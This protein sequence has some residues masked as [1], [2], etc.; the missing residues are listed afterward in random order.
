MPKLA[1]NGRRARVDLS[2][3]FSNS[4]SHLVTKLKDSAHEQ[5][6]QLLM[7]TSSK[8]G[9]GT[10]TAAISIARRLAASENVKVLLIDANFMDPVLHQEFNVPLSP[11]LSEMVLNDAKYKDACVATSINHL[12]L[13][14]CG[15]VDKNTS[16]IVGS[17]KLEA[18]LK[19]LK[20]HYDYIVTDSSAVLDTSEPSL[21][22]RL[23][24]GILLVVECESTKWQVTKAAADELKKAGGNLMG[25]V[26][27]RRKYY[28]PRFFYG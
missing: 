22:C 3:E 12:D 14:P 1:Q 15:K 8:S 2:N 24:D 26:L 6:T 7:V 4:L 21:I 25:T 9:E 18:C 23:F 11:G 5:H 10:S 19:E 28:I 17:E 27:N 20:K 13:L 16:W